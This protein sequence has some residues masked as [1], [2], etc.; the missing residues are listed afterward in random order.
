[1]EAEVRVK[2]F[3]GSLG[4][5]LP[6]GLVER[7]RIDVDDKLKVRVEKI[8]DLSFMWGKGKDVRKSTDQIM[9][10]IDE[11]EDE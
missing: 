8:V 11:G 10:E 9:R 7:E 1:M 2:K 5:I 3:G 6:R 4:I